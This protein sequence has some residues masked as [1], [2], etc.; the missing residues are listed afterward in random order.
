MTLDEARAEIGRLQGLLVQFDMASE[1]LAKRPDVPVVKV[2]NISDLQHL[3]A[4]LEAC[5]RRLVRNDRAW[6]AAE[7]MTAIHLARHQVDRHTMER[8]KELA[9]QR[10]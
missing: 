4:A 10:G 3:G 9:G 6:A 8:L 7:L 1:G 5:A 2:A